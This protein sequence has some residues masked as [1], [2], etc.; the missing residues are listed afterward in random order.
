MPL[1]LTS[2]PLSC[3]V[4]EDLDPDA[5]MQKQL[6][7]M[8]K[9]RKEKETKLKAQEKKVNY[10]STLCCLEVALSV[11]GKPSTCSVQCIAANVWSSDSNYIC[12]NPLPITRNSG[13]LQN[14]CT[15]V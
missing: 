4:M 13:R 3:K 8:E 10:S 12:A 5:I 15:K 6:H 14:L 11:E 7:Q 2:S 9:E 1:P